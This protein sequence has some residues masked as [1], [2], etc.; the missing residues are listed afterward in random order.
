MYRG[1]NIIQLRQNILQVILFVELQEGLTIQNV[2]KEYIPV[3]LLYIL[4]LHPANIDARC[5]EDSPCQWI[6]R[7]CAVFPLQY[8]M[9]QFPNRFPRHYDLVLT[10]W[11]IILYTKTI[12]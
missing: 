3:S 9:L 4:Y 7:V 1:S 10:P 2:I 11:F 5:D 6:Q 8:D 12:D